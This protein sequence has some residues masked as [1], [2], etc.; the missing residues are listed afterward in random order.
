MQFY[1]QDRR[2]GGFTLVE[3]LVVMAIVAIIAGVAV[4]GIV[5][6]LGE[7]RD[8]M[9]RSARTL[10]T[11]LRA[12]RIYA[13]ANRVDTAVV[14]RLDNAW[15]NPD[16]VQWM[17]NRTFEE[18][19]NEFPGAVERI[20]DSLTG[21]T[22]RVGQAIAVVRKL[23]P[24]ELKQLNLSTADQIFVPV[25]AEEGEFEE[26]PGD[27][28]LLFAVPG[29]VFLAVNQVRYPSGG[30]PAPVLNEQV[31]LG[32]TPIDVDFL[33]GPEAQSDGS[34]RFVSR[35]PRSDNVRFRFPAHVFKPSGALDVPG[36]TL[37][38]FTVLIGPQPDAPL[39]ERFVD[40][41]ITSPE[42]LR[43]IPINLH[44]STGRVEIDS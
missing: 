25:E 26:F 7:S 32:M 31:K 14:Y 5:R 33:A 30:D 10:Y 35:P 42:G 17:N 36:S 3:L 22:V 16:P 28:S 43:S 34:V 21:D 11:M 38:R 19:N 6:L 23:K 27:M 20:Q 41:A 40:P 29:Q 4:P 37:E 2:A 9:S 44:R 15:Q 12:A 8:E 18:V 24:E 13:S 1:R 39:E